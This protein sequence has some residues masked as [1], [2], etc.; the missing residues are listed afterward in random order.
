M[1]YRVELVRIGVVAVG[2]SHHK[3]VSGEDRESVVRTSVG[4]RVL[5]PPNL[6]RTSRHVA[7]GDRLHVR[8]A[9]LAVADVRHAQVGLVEERNENGPSV[10]PSRT[11]KSVHAWGFS[12][13]D[14]PSYPIPSRADQS[15]LPTPPPPL[16]PLSRTSW[17]AYRRDLEVHVEPVGREV[18][19]RATLCEPQQDV[20]LLELERRV[21]QPVDAIL[22]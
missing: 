21:E 8:Q 16:S 5:V 3:H 7:D 10:S 17:Q 19:R 1:T 9:V 11:R 13:K 6:P 2:G 12:R 15:I 22:C 14:V 4:E 20:A 18:G